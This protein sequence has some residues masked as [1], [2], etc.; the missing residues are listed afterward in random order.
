M[1]NDGSFNSDHFSLVSTF[2]FKYMLQQSSNTK[3][4][5]LQLPRIIQDLSSLNS[6]SPNSKGKILL[7]AESPYRD[8]CQAVKEPCSFTDLCCGFCAIMEISEGFGGECA[9]VQPVCVWA[10]GWPCQAVP[11]PRPCWK[12]CWFQRL[13]VFAVGK[14]AFQASRK[15]LVLGSA[16]VLLGGGGMESFKDVKLHFEHM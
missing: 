7:H 10:G 6:Y 13:F 8:F 2:S 16:K 1:T 9:S 12:L 3:Y 11:A 5:P 4:F 15:G 14:M